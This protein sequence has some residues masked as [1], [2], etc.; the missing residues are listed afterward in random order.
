MW[1]E[2]NT[3]PL[4]VGVQTFRVTLKISMVVSLKNGNKSAS[5]PSI[6]LLG[7]YPKDVHL[8]KD[9]CSTMFIAALFIIVIT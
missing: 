1:N 7:I 5:R 9:F 6:L 8:Y 3:S 2:Q 4:L